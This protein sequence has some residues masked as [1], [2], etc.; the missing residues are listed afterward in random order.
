[1]RTHKGFILELKENEIFVFGSNLSGIHGKGAAKTARRWGAKIGEGEGLFGQTYALPTVKENIFDG[2]L[3]LYDIQ[4]HI[5]NFAGCVL[6]NPH[7]E[8]L[9]TEVGCGLAGY[10]VDQIAPLFKQLRELPNIV[11]P[12]SFIPF[13]VV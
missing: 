11:W 10:S 2:S 8:F 3:S 5:G 7:L 13:L 12:K 4:Y 1:M 9:L 6:E